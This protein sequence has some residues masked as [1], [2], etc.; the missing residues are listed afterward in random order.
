[1]VD[2][3]VRTLRAKFRA[4]HESGCFVL[5]NPWDIGSARV[6]EQLG[7]QALASTS[8]GFAWSIGQRD[9]AVT[10]DDAL[11]H[12][13]MLAAAV[14][15]PVNADFEGGFAV[16]PDG[17]AANVTRAVHTG[18]AGLSIED[19]TG[20]ASEPLF[21]LSLAAERMAAA[22]AAI[23]AVDSSTMLV[24]RCELYLTARPSLDETI[25]R[26]QAYAAAGADC[27]YAPGVKTRDEIAAIVRAVAPKPVNVVVNTP[28][29]T[30]E[31]LASLGVRRVSV[32]G[33]LARAAWTGFIAAA[34]EIATSGTFV[35]LGEATT[36][37]EMHT[38]FPGEEPA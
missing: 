28:F 18:V 2:E 17:V 36:T 11:A 5:P 33:A 35:R 23:D 3:R 31:E 32:G 15:V 16:D 20:D 25:R 8:A 19:S 12:L 22:R 9:N 21:P 6:L 10:L 4:L 14:H 30:V 38:W 27:L 26:L 1:M 24:G 13:R 34:R 37:K 29:T 7:F